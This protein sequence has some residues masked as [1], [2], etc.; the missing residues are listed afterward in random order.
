[1]SW[2]RLY[3]LV[4][5]SLSE[6]VPS[7]K[8]DWG[9]TGPEEVWLQDG[10]TPPC[11]FGRPSWLRICSVGILSKGDRRG[12]G[13]VIFKSYFSN[14][15]VFLFWIDIFSVRVKVI[16]RHKCFNLEISLNYQFLVCENAPWGAKV[17]R[18]ETLSF[19]SFFPKD[20]EN[21]NGLDIG[22]WEVAAKS[23]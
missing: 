8:G 10:G 3:F 13:G 17:F 23:Q 2:P 6:Y 5:Y 1:M 14:N 12:R 9:Y 20:W 18:S 22:L 7:E 4:Q 21:L 15:I 16:F 19:H 11:S